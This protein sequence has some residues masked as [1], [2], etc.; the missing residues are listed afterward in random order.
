MKICFVVQRYGN[1]VNGGA[2]AYARQVAEHLVSIGGHE[3]SCATTKAVDYT[4]WANSYTSD[5]EVINGVKVHRFPVVE[6][7][8]QAVFDQISARVFGGSTSL[9]EQEEWMRKQG[10]NSP[11]LVEYVAN[12]VDTYDVFIFVCYLYYSTYFALPK[13]GK[14]AIFIPTAHDETPIYLD[15]FIEMFKQP[16]AF[17]YN[18][19]EEKE[20][21]NELFEVAGKPDNDGRGGVGIEIPS[22]VDAEAFKKKFGLDDFIIY[23]GRIDENKCCNILFDYFREYKK[24]NPECKTKLV[25]MGKE[26]IEVPKCDDI[27][28]LGFVSEE[29]KFSGIKA[30]R[31]LILPSRF[32][33]LSIV[34][35]EAMA[36]GKPVMVNGNCDVL[37][38][39]IKRSDAGFYYKNYFEFE[40]ELNYM[41]DPANEEVVS[42]M[43]ENGLDYIANNY[44]W[45]EIVR[46]YEELCKK[47]I[48]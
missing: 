44:S 34:V 21:T 45:E 15:I 6:E 22:G 9:A 35:L 13:V 12:N 1:E 20:L 3:V 17:Y 16:A 38:G 2:E 29:D 41:L 10:P 39:H 7:R 24:C 8:N 31:L 14:K 28:S 37:E 33:S 5:E 18:T 48:K 19:I 27:V 36:L 43:G 46:G 26:V 4:T 42:K 47:I 40:G 25:L 32:E 23:V 30:S 11:A